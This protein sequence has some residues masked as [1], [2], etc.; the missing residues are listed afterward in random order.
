MTVE[1]A[2]EA[3]KEDEYQLHEIPEQFLQLPVG[4]LVQMLMSPKTEELQ[5]RSN[6]EW[7]D[8]IKEDSDPLEAAKLVLDWFDDKVQAGVEQEG[9]WEARH[10]RYQ[11]L[12]D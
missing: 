1:K 6:E 11:S 10:D 8:L 9:I 7:V 4:E 3:L 5:R 12:T 2:L